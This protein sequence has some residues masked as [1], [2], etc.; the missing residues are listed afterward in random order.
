M[1]RKSSQNKWKIIYDKIWSL[2]HRHTLKYRKIFLI[3]RWTQR[4]IL[5]DAK[6]AQPSLTNLWNRFK[7]TF[8]WLIWSFRKLCFNFRYIISF[9]FINFFLIRV[10]PSGSFL[11]ATK[12]NKPINKTIYSK[13]LIIRTKT[14][15]SIKN[16]YFSTTY[17]KRTR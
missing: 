3:S 17:Y 2:G 8:C 1:G 9:I 16:I 10:T 15:R 5:I 12:Y 7:Q 6:Q 14:Q 11:S 13:T 4:P